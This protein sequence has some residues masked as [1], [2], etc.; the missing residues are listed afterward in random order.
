MRLW[1]LTKLTIVI[2]L[3]YMHMSIHYFVDL[4]YNILCQLYLGV[5]GKSL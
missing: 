1:I 5:T 2:I 4:E 3:Q